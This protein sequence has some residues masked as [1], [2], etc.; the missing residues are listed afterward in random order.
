MT[1][2]LG[3]WLMAVPLVL[4]GWIT[5][6]A[7]VARLGGETPALLVLFPPDG[8]IA[9]LPDGVAV[10]DAGPVSLTVSGGNGLAAQLYRIGAPLVLPARLEGC[11]PRARSRQALGG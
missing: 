4:A 2:D 10:V 7:L 6:L 8:L 5:V 1:T 3:R 11:L 9:A